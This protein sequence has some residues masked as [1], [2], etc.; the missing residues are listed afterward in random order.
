MSQLLT[1]EQELVIWTGDEKER[2]ARG[3]KDVLGYGVANTMHRFRNYE[4][5]SMSGAEISRSGMVRVDSEEAGR[6]L[7]LRPGK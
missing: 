7:K 5:F 4:Q 3:K 2:P 6:S 1:G